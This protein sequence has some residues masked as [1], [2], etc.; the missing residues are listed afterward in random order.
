MLQVHPFELAPMSDAGLLARPIHENAAHGFG[1]GPE[2]VAP[3]APG[4]MLLRPHQAQPGFMNQ[5]GGLQRLARLLLGHLR[6]RQLAQFLINQREQ[7][8][9]SLA[10]A[11]INGMEQL[12]DVGH[13]AK[14]GEK[15]MK[16]QSA[17]GQ[18]GKGLRPS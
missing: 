14:V 17:P 7:L 18:N 4:H 12:G 11:R 9:S 2:E 1:S 15:G 3:S 16:G 10:I 6:G 5:R 13:G 8:I